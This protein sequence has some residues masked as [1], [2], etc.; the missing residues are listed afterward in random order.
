MHKGGEFYIEYQ[1][2]RM[3][4]PNLRRQ[5]RNNKR[6]HALYD[7]KPSGKLAIAP[8]LGQATTHDGSGQNYG[9]ES[10]FTVH[11][12]RDGGR[13]RYQNPLAISS[14]DI[15]PRLNQVQLKDD[16]KFDIKN[17]R[18][19]FQ[20]Q[21]RSHRKANCWRKIHGFDKRRI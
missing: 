12:L 17:L 8:E 9:G 11:L 19:P 14:S 2:R 5:L 16:S 10:V 4:W 20:V 3:I 6:S 21:I 15:R 13:C 1:H 7:S 18:F